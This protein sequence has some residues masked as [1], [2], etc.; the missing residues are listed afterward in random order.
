MLE[1][2]QITPLE[3]IANNSQL[4]EFLR[5]NLSDLIT[6]NTWMD[7]WIQLA[8]RFQLLKFKKMSAK[9]IKG[10]QWD[11]EHVMSVIK[12]TFLHVSQYLTF[13]EVR[14]TVVP[15]LPFPFFKDQPQ[16]LWTNAYT[17]GPGN[18][19]IA[20]PPEPDIEFFQYLLAH[21]FHHA[22]PENPIYQLSLDTF[23]LEEWYKMEG[24][25]EYFSLSLYPDKRWWKNNFPIEIESRYWNECKDH[26]KSTDDQIKTPLCFG[27]QK[28]QIPVFSGYSFALK[29]V[30]KYLLTNKI[31]DMRDLFNVEASSFID[32]Y[33]RNS[34]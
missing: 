7:E 5:K 13:N 2:K 30:S 27:S 26:L 4:D 24:T 22:T 33:M 17:N 9:D 12:E 18:I 1:I 15:A 31:D 32:C 19:I 23:T 21:E 20:I 16:S 3:L 6:S 28:K 11:T 10:L 8:Q 25:A 29:L 14:V 34:S